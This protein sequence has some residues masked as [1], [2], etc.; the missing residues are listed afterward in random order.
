M[1]SISYFNMPGSRRYFLFCAAILALSMGPF[2]SHAAPIATSHAECAAL[3]GA[4]FSTVPDAPTQIIE[5]KTVAPSGDVPAY[6]QASGYVTPNVGFVLRMV[7]E[8]W[9]GKFIE[10]GCLGF[11]GSTDIAVMCDDPVRKGYA[12]IVSDNGHKSTAG[13]A[14]WAY[15]NAVAEI[16]HA[17]RGAHVTALAGKAIVERFYGRA[18]RKSYFMGCSTG[19][20]QAM[21]EAQRFPWDFNGIV[22][23]APSLSV[24]GVHMNILWT[25]RSLGDKAGA[26]LLNRA[27]LT[28]LHNA[29]LAKC[30]LGDGIQDGLIANPRSCHF[31]PSELLCTAGKKTQCLSAPQIAAVKKMYN[32]PVNSNG[33]AIYVSGAFEGSELTWLDL[34][35]KSMANFAQEEFRYSAFEP[36]AGPMWK[37][38]DFDFD[39]DYK[40]LGVEE[41]L[42]SAVNPDLR[43]FK[44]AGGKLL[45]YFGWNDLSGMGA[46]VD[47]FETATKILG[48]PANT[49]DFYRLFAIPGM[50]HCT[51]GEGAYAV[52][53]LKYLDDWVE[54]GNAPETLLSSHL[55]LDKPNDFMQLMTLKFPLDPVQ[56]EFSR[57]VY[58]YPILA[59]YKG[60]G[61]PNKAESFGPSEP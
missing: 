60:T 36:N 30:D 40:R 45:S 61:D 13:D 31:E 34:P 7:Q 15:N 17:F 44:A 37:S 57:P 8:N 42:S 53:Y 4:D 35:L 58:P 54:T 38:E 29:V 24:T 51:G 12:C 10:L 2:R 19:G 26:S 32:G 3:A 23:G 14:K 39:R 16:D 33:E 52:D 56:V 41:S 28:L 9:N 50:N 6:C 25:A 21:M 20:R 5:S 1:S 43:K 59:K 18:A 55:R 49:Q 27:D 48:G 46:V 11:C 22:A 47:Y